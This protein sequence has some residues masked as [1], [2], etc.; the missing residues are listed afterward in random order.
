MNRMTLCA[1]SI[2]CALA[3]TAMA[4]PSAPSVDVYGSNNL[5]FSKIELAMETTAGYNQM[6]KY[7]EEAPITLKFN[8]WSGVTGNTYKIYFDGVEVAPVQSVVAKLP[9][10][11]LILRVAFI[12]W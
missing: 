6:V 7:H 3:S 10:S 9:P 4:A 8:Q 1:A 5:Q 2:A 11:L 12:N